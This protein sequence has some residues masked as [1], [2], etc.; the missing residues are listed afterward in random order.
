MNE[1]DILLAS[2]FSFYGASVTTVHSRMTM[3][4]AQAYAY[5]TLNLNVMHTTR[6]YRELLT[7]DEAKAKLF[8]RSKFATATFS[9]TFSEKRDSA[10]IQH[11]SL[12]CFDFD[13]LGNRR[14]EIRNKLI[15]DHNFLT[16]LL[17]TSPSGDGLKWVIG[18]DLTK[19][20]HRMW[21]M[22]VRNYLQITYGVETDRC[23]GN[24]SRGCF[25]PHDTMCHVNPL[26]L[27]QP[28]V[29]PF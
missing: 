16:A 6:E 13:H 1:R 15:D 28:G 3:N 11:S 20:D 23:C 21:F 22:A 14:N 2:Q 19:G 10:L 17:F 7:Q 26:I 27:N 25:L 9:G 12:I 4:I 18:I 29:C 8:K 5:I 24:L